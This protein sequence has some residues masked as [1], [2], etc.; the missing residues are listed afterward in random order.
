MNYSPIDQNTLIWVCFT[1]YTITA[2]HILPTTVELPVKNLDISN[3]QALQ[4][5]SRFVLRIALIF[6]M[7]LLLKNIV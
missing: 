2:L 3:Q 5:A 6:P 1:A 7:I 4:F